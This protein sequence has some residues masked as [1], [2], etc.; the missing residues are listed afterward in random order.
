MPRGT[1]V[2]KKKRVATEIS[3]LLDAVKPDGVFLEEYYPSVS[4]YQLN[5]TYQQ[6]QLNMAL[7][8]AVVELCEERDVPCYMVHSPQS[9][10]APQPSVSLSS[11]P[12]PPTPPPAR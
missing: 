9:L 12:S 8:F 6:R 2:Q 1:H 4:A 7:R 3:T 10:T 11:P 5:A